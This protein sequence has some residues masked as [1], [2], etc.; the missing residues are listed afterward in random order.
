MVQYVF[1]TFP[2]QALHICEIRWG[3]NR[4][5]NAALF[6]VLWLVHGNKCGRV[7]ARRID[8]GNA[9]FAGEAMMIG[10]YVL[11]GIVTGD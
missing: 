10:F 3:Y 5:D 9:G 4:C 11:D 2:D 1:D 8:D 7:S 6:V